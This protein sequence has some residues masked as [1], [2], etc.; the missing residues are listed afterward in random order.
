MSPPPPTPATPPTPASPDATLTDGSTSLLSKSIE[1]SAES[2]SEVKPEAKPPEDKPAKP[3]AGA[4]EKY[5]PFTLPEGVTLEGET[6]EQAHGLFKEMGLDQAQSQKLVDF[7]AK[8]LT[9]AAQGPYKLWQE[10]QQVWLD[11]LRS[12]PIIGKDIDNGVVGAAVAKMINLMPP[13][14]AVAF[15]EALNFTG[16][17]NHPAIARGLLSL[18]KLYTE[19]GHVQGK[20]PKIDGA[21]GSSGG[22]PAPGASLYPTLPSANKGT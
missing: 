19:P 12:D 10:T 16:A 17:G 4:P 2:G 14:Q 6:L 3:T 13:E 18:S 20:G 7:H 5:T 8:Q 21:P 9:E 15:R 22:R 1:A 11:E